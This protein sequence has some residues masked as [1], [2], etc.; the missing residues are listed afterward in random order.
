MMSSGW[1]YAILLHEFGT[2]KILFSCFFLCGFI[3]QAD[4]GYLN[5]Y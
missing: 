1:I 2:I 5:F 4:I 3:Q